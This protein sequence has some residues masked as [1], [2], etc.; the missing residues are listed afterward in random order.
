MSDT[1]GKIKTYKHPDR[2]KPVTYKPYVPQ[3]QVEGVEPREYQGAVVPGAVVARPTTAD[4]PK[5]EKSPSTSTI[6]RSSRFT[7]WRR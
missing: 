3:Y 1:N 5:A 7:R 6:C 4:N 2:E